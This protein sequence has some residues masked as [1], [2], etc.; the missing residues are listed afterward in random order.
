MAQPPLQ[1][2]ESFF[3]LVHLEAVP[4]YAHGPERS[5]RHAVGMKLNL[6]TL[7]DQPGVWRVT[8]DIRD[9]DVGHEIPRYHFR[10]RVVGFFRWT[11]E[12]R[13]E[14]QIAQLMAV[15]GTSMLYS[16]AREYLLMLTS[17]APWGQLSLPTISFAD[18][19]VTP[20]DDS[21]EADETPRRTLKKSAKSGKSVRS[22]TVKKTRGTTSRREAK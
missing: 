13:P 3:D 5:Q 12:E 10:L 7:D 21:E 8:L 17:R 14:D 1:L 22:G 18:V 20:E 19:S 4:E 11:A 15:N 2:E 9:D 16:S 6:A